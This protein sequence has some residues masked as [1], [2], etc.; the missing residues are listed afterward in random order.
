MDCSKNNPHSGGCNGLE[1][2]L[3]Y[4]NI[5][6]ENSIEFIDIDDGVDGGESSSLKWR[7][8]SQIG[9]TSLD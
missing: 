9:R 4:L 7:S 1:T 5:P 2:S 8:G 3:T 6:K